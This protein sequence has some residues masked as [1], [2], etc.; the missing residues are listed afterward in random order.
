MDIQ[1]SDKLARFGRVLGVVGKVLAI[2][3]IFGALASLFFAIAIALLSENFALSVIEAIG[4]PLDAITNVGGTTN[5]SIG[6]FSYSIRIGD[7]IPPALITSLKVV[8]ILAVL[9]SCLYCLVS[10]IILFVLSAMFKAT[11]I[12]KTPFL[13]ENVRR[14]KIIGVVLIII[15]LPLG[16][17][18]LILAFCI[19]AF[20]YV[21]QYGVELQQQA[22]ET[23]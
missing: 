2:I 13:A 7:F 21:V 1:I 11:A 18:N 6:D 16:L 4:I 22:D 12:N 19:F 17:H 9:A 23:L 14:L 3:C 15:S 8:L 5:I 20:A 10:A